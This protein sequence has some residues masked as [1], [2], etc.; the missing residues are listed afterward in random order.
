MAQ[1]NK[2]KRKF[3]LEIFNK[4]LFILIIVCGVY[5]L[6]GTNDISVK[7]FKLQEL[8]LKANSLNNENGNLNI[9][10]MSL[11]SYS[12]VNQR[13]AELDMVA[14]GEMEYITMGAGAVAIKR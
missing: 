12:D 2:N 13:V 5:Y 9:R 6:T 7:S 1:E 3:N 11:N 4:I 10:Q 14:A 8:K